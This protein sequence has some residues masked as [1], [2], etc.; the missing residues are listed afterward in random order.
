MK[1]EEDESRILRGRRKTG[2]ALGPRERSVQ[3]LAVRAMASG[4][5]PTVETLSR[6]LG[7]PVDTVRKA[8]ASLEA[9][10]CVVMEGNRVR[11]AYPFTMDPV[12]HEVI[13]SHGTARAN[14]AIDALGT[15][16]MLGEEIEI[17]SVCSYCSAPIRLRGRDSF[18]VMTIGPVVFV[19]ASDLRQ[20]HASDCV[21]PSISFYCNEEHG[22]AH[23][24][25]PAARGRLLSLD[26][27]T[28]LGI[29]AFGDLLESTPA[30]SGER[31][32]VKV[33]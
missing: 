6:E 22:Q 5:A 3:R 11:V 28:A 7:L 14:C 29:S 1:S 25:A 17:R 31:R 4:R 26:Q 18:K 10:D 16:A 30:Q 20:G 19:P 15:G 33:E 23:A 21:C 2:Q 9:C 24:R 27:A 32:P 8:L 13:S 12:P